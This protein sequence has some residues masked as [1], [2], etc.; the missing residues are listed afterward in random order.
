MWKLNFGNEMKIEILKI[1][2]RIEI[3]GWIL[4]YGDISNNIK[5]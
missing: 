4:Q 3:F 1:R 2:F 5:I